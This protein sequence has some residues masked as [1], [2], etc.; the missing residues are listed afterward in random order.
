MS[1]KD[2]ELD[3]RLLWVAVIVFT[4]AGLGG[5]ALE[6]LESR[7]VDRLERRVA[8]LEATRRAAAEAGR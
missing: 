4:I 5:L 1:D 7:R 3:V 2:M 8:D 6:L